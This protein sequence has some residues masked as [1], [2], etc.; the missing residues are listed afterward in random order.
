MAIFMRHIRAFEQRSSRGQSDLRQ[1]YLD[2]SR[3][4]S[5][6]SARPQSRNFQ[7]LC[8]VNTPWPCQ[9]SQR[10]VPIG[11]SQTWCNVYSGWHSYS[12]C[13][14]IENILD[15]LNQF[16]RAVILRVVR[17]VWGMSVWR[18]SAGLWFTVS[19][20]T[21]SACLDGFLSDRKQL[22]FWRTLERLVEGQKVV[23]LG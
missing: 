23:A 12:M 4:F 20:M 17:G 5:L 14:I 9:C 15:K 2:L 22:L 1:S 19:E 7:F 13:I 11:A 8:L 3:S 18:S 21:S 10:V 6:K 16:C